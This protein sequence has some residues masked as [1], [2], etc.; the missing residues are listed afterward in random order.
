M[1]V[2]KYKFF[3]K[4][5]SIIL[6]KIF[7]ILLVY[8]PEQH[9]LPHA[10]RKLPLLNDSEYAETYYSNAQMKPYCLPCVRG[11]KKRIIYYVIF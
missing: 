9:Y 2:K 1:E 6:L 7:S 5:N 4:L 10:I 11:L 3:S 8:A